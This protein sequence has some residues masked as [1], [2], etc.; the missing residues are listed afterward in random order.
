MRIKLV[1][2]AD[3]PI[4]LDIS[5]NQQVQGMIY[6]GIGNDAM[7]SFLHEHGFVYEKRQFRLFVYSRLIGC[8]HFDPRTKR[9]T[10]IPPL[11]LYVSSPWEDFLHNLIGGLTRTPDLDLGEN[12]I[13]A[14]E[15]AFEQTPAFDVPKIYKINM[16]SPVTIYSTLL[17]RDGGKKTYYYSPPEKEFSDLI[18]LNLIK[19]AQA[20]YDED[21]S[22]LPFSL[23]PAG[24]IHSTQQK[25]IIYKGFVIKGWM[26]RFSLSGDPR[27]LRLAFDAGCGSKNS[28]GLGMFALENQT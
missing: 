15:V 19:K 20:F 10:F 18:R 13:R 5:H 23:A 9:I 21:W 26:G 11:S 3:R 7:Q 17:T 16:L 6:H 2:Q 4:T 22:S 25:V 27:M 14:S 1:F 12:R 8:S 24:N 28:Q